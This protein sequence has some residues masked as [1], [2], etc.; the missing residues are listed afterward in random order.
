MRKA[1]HEIERIYIAAMAALFKRGE[2]SEAMKKR[3]IYHHLKDA[4]RELGAAVDI[5]HRIIVIFA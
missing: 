2:A 4:G 5:L 3:E 1:E